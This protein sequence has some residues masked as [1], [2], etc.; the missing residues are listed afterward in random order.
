M[1][2]PP[3]ARVGTLP[4][5]T[6]TWIDANGQPINPDGT[7]MTGQTATPLP[8]TPAA[9]TQTQ[10]STTPAVSGSSAVQVPAATNID[11]NASKPVAQTSTSSTQ[12]PSQQ[13][14]SSSAAAGQTSPT[15]G[16]PQGANG[17]FSVDQTTAAAAKEVQDANIN[18]AAIWDQINKQQ[19]VV[20]GITQGGVA[21]DPTGTKLQNATSTLNT[22][23]S[24]LSSAQQRVETA[25]AA[26]STTLTNAIK[27][28]Q[29][30]PSQVALA[31]A[32]AD[33]ASKNADTAAKQVDVLEQGAP[34]Q[35]ALVAA[36]AGAASASAAASQATADATKLKAGPEA[37]Q[38]TQQAAALKAQA[39]QTNALIGTPDNPGPLIRKSN[40]EVNTQV[41]TTDQVSA[42]AALDRANAAQ[43]TSQ[44]KLVDVQT[45]TAQAS[46]A[47]GA[48]QAAVA[49]V[50]AQTAANQATAQSTLEGIKQKQ[51]GPM[52]GLQDQINAI[53][54]I[55]GQVF[56]PGGTGNPSHAD[57][58]LQQYV[59]ATIGG[60]T[61][62]AASVATAN[63]QQNIFG[64]QAAMQNQQ[65]QAAASRANTF[66]NFAGGTLGQIAQLNAY[67]PKGSTAGAAMYQAMMDNMTQRMQGPAFTPPPAPQA[68]PLPTFL[69][70]FAAGHQAGSS[71]ASSAGQSA[72]TVN[73][74]VNGQPASSGPAA[75]PAPAPGPFNPQAST[76]AMNAAG[77][78][79][80]PAGRAA[81]ASAPGGPPP[82]VNPVSNAGGQTPQQS[83][84]QGLSA[85]TPPMPNY[86]SGLVNPLSMLNSGLALRNAYN[87]GPGAGTPTA[88][89]P[90]Y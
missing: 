63:A 19:A 8:P 38:L 70:G 11:P 5:G 57:D 43:A 88:G 61:P 75:A 48:P 77:F 40:E 56:G 68:P 28:N 59:D 52:Y 60:T 2:L 46:L 72:P 54:A 50:Q 79:D 14:Q 18:T 55:A 4:D 84:D 7:P 10:T 82:G 31:T 22:L 62:Y 17:L 90:L 41:A 35:R 3:G 20:D 21:G 44:S 67:A 12:T 76:A 66:A 39:D 32:Q 16:A 69:Q 9:Q 13:A 53:H 15:V 80:T 25:N 42:Q 89:S 36:Q 78:M 33:A 34:G 73:I 49:G 27:A 47:A 58:L 45:Q 51:L 24:S 29:V 65:V 87:Q 23:Y 26:Y 30:D 85:N 37:D 71:Q 64:T 1:P 86:L 81:M 6:L 83:F 74:N